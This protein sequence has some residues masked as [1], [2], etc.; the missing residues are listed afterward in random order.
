MYRDTILQILYRDTPANVLTHQRN[1]RMLLGLYSHMTI[2]QSY[3]IKYKRE[4]LKTFHY[5]C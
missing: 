2:L 4:N 3:I 1:Q 5:T